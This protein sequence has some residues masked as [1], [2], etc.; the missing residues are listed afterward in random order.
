MTTHRCCM[1]LNNEYQ[2]S[3]KHPKTQHFQHTQIHC[4]PSLVTTIDQLQN[5][6][7]RKGTSETIFT[8]T[9]QTSPCEKTLVKH[10]KENINM[11]HWVVYPLT[12]CNLAILKHG[13]SNHC[14]IM[15]T[16]IHTH[17]SHAVP[18]HFLMVAKESGEQS[19]NSNNF[20]SG[21]PTLRLNITPQKASPIRNAP[22]TSPNRTLSPPD[23]QGQSRHPNTFCQWTSVAAQQNHTSRHSLRQPRIG[24]TK[25]STITCKVNSSPDPS[26]VKSER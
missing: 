25:L 24:R 8:N 23:V 4:I 15:S 1:Q 2:H 19:G 17:K 22:E 16:N 12:R 21:K 3:K 10:I 14:R 11:I 7:N 13:G 5:P 18:R 26:F 20:P 6:E 9:H